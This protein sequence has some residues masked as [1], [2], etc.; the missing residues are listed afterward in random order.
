MIEISELHKLFLECKKVSTDSRNIE[1][2]SIFFSLKGQNFN[3]NQFAGQ[4]LSKGAKY[5]IVDDPNV[6]SNNSYILVSDVLDTLQKLANFHRNQ[7]TIPVIAIT[8]TNGKTTTKE[9]INAVLSKK[10]KTISTKGNL[11]NHIGVPLTL[12]EI[13]E[14]TEIAIIEMGANHPNEIENLCTMANPNLGIITNIGKAHLEGFGSFDGVIKTKT[15]LYR[16]LNTNKG[17]IFINS[18]DNILI[19]NINNINC[20]IIK[21]GTKKDNFC[22]G[23]ILESELF[24]SFSF[25]SNNIPEI[26]VNTN[27]IGQY[28]FFNALSAV[29]YGLYFNVDKL[30]IK[31]AIE[32]Y[33]PQNNRSQLLKTKYNTIILD[34]YNANPTS[35]S[36]AIN[37]FFNIKAENKIII[38]GDMFE[39]GDYAM[40]EHNKIISLL[41]DF[42]FDEVYLVGTN[43]GSIKHNKYKTFE[44]IETLKNELLKNN[45]KN[46]TILIKGSR[47]MKMEQLTEVL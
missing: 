4:A 34:A 35:M 38:L 11:N 3:G 19:D 5:A 9:L 1:L 33:I 28:N 16:Y 24:L 22:Y 13:N 17:T 15:E 32:N 7:F 21:Y 12:L 46:K 27:L 29:A 2:N 23:K 41:E 20:E 44:D 40:N 10:Y 25:A 31:E 14:N 45:I 37:N 43:F 8:G 36:A 26:K 18:T 30:L 42:N 39:L 6:V 47:G